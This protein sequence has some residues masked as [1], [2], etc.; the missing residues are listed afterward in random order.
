MEEENIRKSELTREKQRLLWEENMR[1]KKMFISVIMITT[2]M[3][4]AGGCGKQAEPVSAEPAETVEEA[5]TE[6]SLEPAD[7]PVAGPEESME[8]S[9]APDN[10]ENEVETTEMQKMESFP[11]MILLCMQLLIVI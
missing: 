2:V 3:L 4:F 1:D 6:E 7:S 5:D 8:S 9:E 11:L 10:S